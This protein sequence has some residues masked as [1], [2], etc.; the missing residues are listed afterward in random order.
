MYISGLYIK[1]Y[2]T[3]NISSNLKTHAI[4]ILKLVYKYHL[5][6]NSYN[7][8]EYFPYSTIPPKIR[9]RVPSTTKP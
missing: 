7:S 9:M 3:G 2:T 1:T 5:T 4:K 8:L 6:C